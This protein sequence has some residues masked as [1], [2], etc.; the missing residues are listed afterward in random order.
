VIPLA[1]VV[2]PPPGK[3][4]YMVYVA[5][6]QG[7]K[8]VAQAQMVQLGDALGDRIAVREGLHAGQ[9]VVVTGASLVH[10]GEMVEIVP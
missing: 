1:A 10:D 2:Q 3:Q 5:G 9:R 4:G 8:A 7:G 6:D